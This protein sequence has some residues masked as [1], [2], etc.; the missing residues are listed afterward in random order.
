MHS[1]NRS[2]VRKMNGFEWNHINNLSIDI[3]SFIF[4]INKPIITRNMA[5]R[6]VEFSDGGTKLEKFCLRINII[7]ENY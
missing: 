4:S 2:L 5:I 7:K 1:S 6:V 3:P